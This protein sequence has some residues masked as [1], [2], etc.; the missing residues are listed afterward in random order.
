M[1]KAS[2]P[3]MK[4]NGEERDKRFTLFWKLMPQEIEIKF[5]S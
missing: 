1:K 2:F 5:V 4:G 3:R